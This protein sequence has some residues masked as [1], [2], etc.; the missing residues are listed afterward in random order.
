MNI[1]A[2]VG[3]DYSGDIDENDPKVREFAERRA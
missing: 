3:P 2:L 1:L